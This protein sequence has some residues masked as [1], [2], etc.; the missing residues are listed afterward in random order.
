MVLAKII[1][2]AVASAVEAELGLLFLNAQELLPTWMAAIDM[3]WPQPAT[4]LK[5]DNSTTHGIINGTVNKKR[6]K[7]MDMRFFG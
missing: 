7:A 6:S 1:K 3:E 5:T 2:M 4:P